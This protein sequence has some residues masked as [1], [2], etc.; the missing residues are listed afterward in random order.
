VA[1]SFI[2]YVWRDL[3]HTRN[4]AVVSTEEAELANLLIRLLPEE[5]YRVTVR[6]AQI[7]D[8]GPDD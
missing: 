6:K 1:G 2:V 4:V 3:P 7:R 8:V 5:G